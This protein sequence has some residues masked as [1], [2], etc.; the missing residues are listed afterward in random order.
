MQ[1]WART[2]KSVR[3]EGVTAG[4]DP[5]AVYDLTL[6]NVQITGAQDS[7]GVN[8][9]LTFSYGQ[10]ALSTKVVSPTGATSGRASATTLRRG[11]SCEHTDPDCG[12]PIGEVATA[13]KYFLLIDGLNGGSTDE[14]HAGWFEIDGFRFRHQHRACR[15]QGDIR[16]ADGAAEPE[17]RPGWR[18]PGCGAG[19]ERSIGADRRRHRG[20]DPVAVY[21]L[22]LG[23]VQMTGAQDS[24]GV[25]DSLTFSYGQVALST[26]VVSPTGAIS[27]GRASATTLRR[28]ILMRAYRPRLWAPRSARLRRLR[29]TSC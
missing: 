13:A 29:S 21:D 1:R 8:D 6:G 7:S 18:A 16:T 19:H 4:P 10:V 11:L 22:T 27:P 2:F 5:V 23:N 20:P 17:Q 28:G 15:G 24:S 9:S 25:N 26:K 12:A 14:H 3:I